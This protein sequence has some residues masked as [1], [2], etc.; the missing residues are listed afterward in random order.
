M[1]LVNDA[2]KTVNLPFRPIGFKFP[3][4][5]KEV[6]MSDITDWI[7]EKN[8]G[9]IQC[10]P[11]FAIW[12]GIGTIASVILGF[13]GIK[14]DNKLFKWG[15]GILGVVG[16]VIIAVGV[17]FGKLVKQIP[18]QEKKAK[19]EQ[20]KKSEDAFQKILETSVINSLKNISKEDETKCEEQRK[21]L[22]S[23]HAK[24]S[25]KVKTLF[26]KI[27]SSS[28]DEGLAKEA[29]LCLKITYDEEKKI[30]SMIVALNNKSA[31]IDARCEAIMDLRFANKYKMVTDALSERVKD[32]SE[33]YRIRENSFLAL[34]HREGYN[35]KD[36]ILRLLKD[37]NEELRGM[38]V[39]SLKR[40]VLEIKNRDKDILKAL[41]EDLKSLQINEN[42]DEGKK[43]LQNLITQVEKIS[44]K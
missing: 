29:E 10:L 13:V 28:D 42:D 20:E 19:E 38:V 3:Q 34:V 16:A 23:R 12:A 18:E 6:T 24:D 35:A 36:L 43:S 33:P 39:T 25:E 15:G 8:P 17:Y 4:G 5:K 27:K 11:H 22:I 44:K 9:P 14:K 30:N 37:P 32:K 31:D 41:L 2:T 40:L 1:L 26:E 7:K 21:E